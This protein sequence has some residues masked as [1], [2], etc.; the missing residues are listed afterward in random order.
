MILSCTDC[1]TRFAIDA[2]KLRPDGRRVKCGKCAHVWF[3]SAPDPEGLVEDEPVLR[4]TPLEPE[5]QS[6][7]PV[8]NLPAILRSKKARSA[9]LGWWVSVLLLATVLAV[10][11]FGRDPI[12]RAVPQ[13]KAVYD[14]VNIK[15]IPAI[16]RR[17]GN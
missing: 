9:K 1:S 2:D 16:R 8:R 6:Y 11:W 14:A 5:E 13:M 3:A 7:V 12:A 17:L 15:A 4:V 10:F